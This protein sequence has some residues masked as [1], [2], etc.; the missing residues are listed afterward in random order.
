MLHTYSSSH[1]WADL[2]TK[3]QSAGVCL[4]DG[5]HHILFSINT[6][7][8]FAIYAFPGPLFQSEHVTMFTVFREFRHT[9]ITFWLLVLQLCFMAYFL[10][11]VAQ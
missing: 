10:G 6:K 11:I 5:D 3:H 7:G 9:G 8:I 1:S 2:L 4:G